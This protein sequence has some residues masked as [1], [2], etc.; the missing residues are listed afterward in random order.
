MSRIRINGP[1][2]NKFISGEYKVEWAKKHILCEDISQQHKGK[3]I[4]GN[5]PDFEM[6]MLGGEEGEMEN[7]ELDVELDEVS[8]DETIN[9]NGFPITRKKAFFKNAEHEIMYSIF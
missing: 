2:P 6:F 4:E 8:S 3:E 9:A 7:E 5:L 1:P